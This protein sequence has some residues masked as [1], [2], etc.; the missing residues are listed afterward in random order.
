MPDF[1]LFVCHRRIPFHL[2]SPTLRCYAADM[3]SGRP[4]LAIA[5]LLLNNP[6]AQA[7]ERPPLLPAAPGQERVRWH[8][9]AGLVTDESIAEVKAKLTAQ[10]WARGTYTRQKAALAP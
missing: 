4:T 7:A 6:L 2:E 10:D 8:H 1:G 3:F 9:P 5:L